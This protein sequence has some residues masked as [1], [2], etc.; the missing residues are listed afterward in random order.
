M[1]IAEKLSPGGV[2][3]RFGSPLHERILSN[4]RDR[5]RIARD[6]QRKKREQAW[7]DS[8]DTFQAYMPETDVTQLRKAGRKAG[9]VEY[10]TVA[11][12]YSYA[13]LLTAHTYY[14]S[15]FLARDPIFQ[16]KTEV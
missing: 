6:E 13:M 4:F 16:M 3:V 10:T 2:N 9:Q 7:A 14:T 12:P 15:V 5:K 11:I 1:K 8:E